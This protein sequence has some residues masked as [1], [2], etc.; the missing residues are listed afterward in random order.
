[1]WHT[2]ITRSQQPLLRKKSGIWGFPGKRWTGSLV[3][4]CQE[5]LL[6]WWWTMLV[7][8]PNPHLVNSQHP[9]LIDQL[10][11]FIQRTRNTW[12]CMFPSPQYPFNAKDPYPVTDRYA[13]RATKATD[14][15]RDS[16]ET[17][18]YQSSPTLKPLRPRP[19]LTDT[20]PT[21]T[22][23]FSSWSISLIKQCLNIPTLFLVSALGG[24]T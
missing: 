17:T 15:G 9:W 1:M 10:C 7:S 18:S 13:V 22:P 19:C 8:H 14:S 23:C 3:D 21:P 12:G 11:L 16:P 4:Y 5:K 2:H 6:A 20:L 24:P